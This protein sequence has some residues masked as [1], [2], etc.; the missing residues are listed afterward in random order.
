MTVPQATSSPSHTDPQI[1]LLGLR[2][3]GKSS[4]LQVLYNHL[5]PNDTLF[6][7]STLKPYAV[8]LDLW[9]TCTVWDGI[10]VS[11]ILQTAGKDHGQVVT[12]V[13]GLNWT[14][15]K[16][17]IWVLDAQVRQ[18]SVAQTSHATITVYSLPLPRTQD[19]YFSSLSSL[20]SLI[21]L[22]Y[23]HN[24]SIQFHVFLHKMDGLSEDYRDDTQTDIEKRIDDNLSDASS[25]F[26]FAREDLAAQAGSSSASQSRAHDE[27]HHLANVD[28]DHLEGA[29][30]AGGNGDV[31]TFPVSRRASQQPNTAPNLETDVDLTIHQTSIF[32]S[33]V[34]VAFSRV[35]QP[36]VFSRP[37]MKAGLIRLVDSLVDA[38]R[39]DKLFLV[40]LPTRTFLV[41]DSSPFD[42]VSFDVVCDYLGF[43]VDFSNLFANLAGPQQ[44]QHR[45]Y[46][47]STLRLN[48]DNLVAFWQVD[49][50]LATIA[51]LRSSTYDGTSALIDA[52]INVFRRA[53]AALLSTHK[54]HT[55]DRL[56]L[57]QQQAPLLSVDV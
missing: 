55:V 31:P 2:R 47:S 8:Q 43:L 56:Q 27:Q 12:G 35:L 4:L 16:S 17:I 45:S 51:I 13:P 42:K 39:F 6:L 23:A 7:E 22:A 21:I 48:A 10:S 24:P 34:F 30:A 1:L 19:D 38:S 14:A 26:V 46:S 53:L 50:S 5:P 9:G 25:T 40:H 18:G 32:D 37:C 44:Q 3:S 20:H 54:G 36:V 28:W 41:S 15:V 29:V 57:Q 49:A 52:N 33:S 11:T